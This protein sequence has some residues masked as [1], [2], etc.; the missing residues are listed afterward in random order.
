MMRT[1]R[2]MVPKFL[3]SYYHLLLARVSAFWYGHP[4]RKLVVIGV[5]GTH[6]KSSV[7]MMLG[8]VLR[9]LGYCVG[10]FSTAT[11][12]DGSDTWLNDM[13]MTMP[14]R[15][16][17]Q[18][19]LQRCALNQCTFVVIETSS[20]GILQ[21][22]HRG[23]DYRIVLLTNIAREH[24]EAHGGFAAYRAAKA[25]L[26][27]HVARGRSPRRT[28]V[29][30][31]DLL[32]PEEF[33]SHPFSEVLSFDR[34][35]V[36]TDG[37][38]PA[39]AAFSDNIAA[40]ETTLAALGMEQ[41]RVHEALLRIES[42]P[43]RM[44]HLD[45]GQ[46]FEVIVDYAHT[47]HALEAVFTALPRI[48]GRT[49]H[50]LGGVGG[51]RDL[52]KRSAM[53][54]VAATFADIVIVTNEDP[55]D[56]DPMQIIQD[57]AGGAVTAWK[58]AKSDYQEGESVLR[59]KD[60]RDAFEKAVKLARSGDRILVTGKGCEQAICGP[61]GVKSPWDDRV[62]LTEVITEHLRVDAE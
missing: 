11:I 7:V 51:G 20:E 44:E 35:A 4:S 2:S 60:R 19:F 18:R 22:R 32:E 30:P 8:S 62:V 10:W 16:V 9:T 47:P 15:F 25:S 12:S 3:V 56:D 29:I 59:V 54:A 24:I 61:G 40:C 45:A 17:L 21:H 39:L 38:I 26:F 41:R 55:Y 37:M 23:I 27:A 52:W 5:T 33:T 36:N 14:G 6:G 31:L 42:L 49:I 13:K 1:I 34:A 43:G 58:Q 28:A 57:V 46:D 50:L 48:A 53:G